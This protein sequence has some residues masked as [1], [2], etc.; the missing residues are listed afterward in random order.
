MEWEIWDIHAS[1]KGFAG[2]DGNDV[3]GVAKR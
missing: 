3:L 1:P 2:H